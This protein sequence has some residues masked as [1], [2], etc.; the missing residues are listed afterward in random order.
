M[1]VGSGTVGG[2]NGDVDSLA[3]V[4]INNCLISV[5]SHVICV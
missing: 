5:A 3:L 4:W 2:G 1:L